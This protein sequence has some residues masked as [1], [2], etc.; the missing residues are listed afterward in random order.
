VPTLS[1]TASRQT[2]LGEGGAIALIVVASVGGLV[3][4]ALVIRFA[5]M[6]WVLNIHRPVPVTKGLG[7]TEIAENNT[8]EV[9]VK[10]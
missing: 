9:Y 1:P 7:M 8:F 5:L 4:L 10:H 2:E 3:L 6:Y